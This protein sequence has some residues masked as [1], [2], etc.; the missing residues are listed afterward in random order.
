LTGLIAV[1]PDLG[2]AA[3]V[4]TT[5]TLMLLVAGVRIGHAALLAAPAAALVALYAAARF[6]HVQTR[7]AVFLDPDADPQGKGYQIRQALIAL[8]SGG[9]AGLGLGGSK[10]KLFFLPDD[11]TDFILAIVGEELGLFG[12]LAVVLLFGALVVHGYRIALAASEREGFLL[13]FGITTLLGLQAA[14][15]LAVV[16]ASMPTKGISLPFVSFG[17]SSLLV[18][19]TEVGVLLSIAG[20]EAAGERRAAHAA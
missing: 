19:M 5:G 13:A 11:H 7:L 14:I 3:L 6:T 20:R 8:G 15:N 10:Q 1:E 18:A 16:T 2:T 12:T 4:A 17:G 9:P